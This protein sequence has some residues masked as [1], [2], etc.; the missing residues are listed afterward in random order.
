MPDYLIITGDNC[1]YCDKA[2]FA[3]AELARQCATIIEPLFSVSWAALT[4]SAT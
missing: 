3:L 4:D 1:P 2:K